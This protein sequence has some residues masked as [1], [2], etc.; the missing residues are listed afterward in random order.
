M[1]FTLIDIILNKFKKK[2]NL[3][4]KSNFDKLNFSLMK[5]NIIKDLMIYLNNGSNL[6]KKMMFTNLILIVFCSFK[7]YS[8]LLLKEIQI[9][10]NNKSKKIQT[11][12]MK[13]SK[14]KRILS[15]LVKSIKL[16]Y[17]KLKMSE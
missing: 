8:L 15:C 9:K 10:K 17:L 2:Q 5:Y 4:Q 12:M 1:E 13:C 11:L 14:Y 16:K 3:M 6:L 7:H